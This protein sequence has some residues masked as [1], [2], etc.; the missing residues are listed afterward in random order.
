MTSRG[1]PKC[2]K[3]AYQCLHD[4]DKAARF[5]N[6][7]ILLARAERWEK[8]VKSFQ[9][10]IERYKAGVVVRSVDCL[11]YGLWREMD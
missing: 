5:W 2:S 1:V 11:G 8:A 4:L 3:V 9:S 6:I 10:A 7:G